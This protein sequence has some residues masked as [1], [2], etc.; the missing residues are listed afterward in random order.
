MR[1][2]QGT[3]QDRQHARKVW[4]FW[5]GHRHHGNSQTCPPGT[6]ASRPGF[7]QKPFQEVRASHGQ[8]SRIRT[9]STSILYEYTKCIKY[10]CILY[11][12]ILFLGYLFLPDFH[13]LLPGLCPYWFLMFC[14]FLDTATMSTHTSA[15]PPTNGSP[16]VRPGVPSLRESAR[17]PPA[18]AAIHL[19]QWCW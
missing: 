8:V 6:K 9:L 10:V 19:Y 7:A 17:E 2:I 15:N 16:G 12:R 18:T 14:Q 3:G 1:T 4:D 5:C 11:I 13:I